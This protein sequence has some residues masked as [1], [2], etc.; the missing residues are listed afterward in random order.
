MGE[1]RR[2]ESW[3][4]IGAYLQKDLRTARRWE[5]EEGLPVHRQTHKR[6][7]SVYAYTSEIDVWRTSRKALPEPPP[8]WK[9]LLTGPRSLAFV[10]LLALFLIMVGNGVRPVVAQQA[11][12]VAKRLLCDGACADNE[13][14][15]STD[16][17]WMVKTDWDTGDLA[18]RDMSTGEMTALKVKTVTFKESSAYAQAPVFSP[19]MRQI[20]YHWQVE[21][22][23]RSQLR[24]MPNEVGGK[25][26]VLVDNPEY[27]YFEPAAWSPDGKSILV[28]V[29]KSS[30]KT[31]Q[32]AW[33][34]TAEG[35][36]RQIVSLGWR[37][38]GSRGR[39]TL[40]GDGRYIAYATLA[41]NPKSATAKPESTDVHIYVVSA[42]GSSGTE[43]VRGAGIN[44]SP[45]W[46]PDGRHLLFTSDRSGSLALWS[47]AMQNGR[48][49]G[50]NALVRA[51]TGDLHTMGVHANSYYYTTR[52]IAQS[53]A[54]TELKYDGKPTTARAE[55]YPGIRPAWSPDGKSIAYKKRDPRGPDG[56]NLVVQSLQTG[57][58]RTYTT[59]LGY[60]GGGNAV[61]MRDSNAMLEGIDADGKNSPYRVD[62]KSGEFTLLPS[63][64]LPSADGKTLYAIRRDP[65][66][67]DRIVAVEID[68][69]QER[70]VFTGAPGIMSI[71]LSPDGQ[72]FAMIRDDPQTKQKHIERVGVD[73]RGYRELCNLARELAGNNLTW[74][75]DSR[76]ILFDKQREDRLKTQIMWVSAEGGLPQFAGVEL[77]GRP[78]GMDVSPDGLLLAYGA[79]KLVQEMWALDNLLP[80]PK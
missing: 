49:V 44:N 38:P 14:N 1:E 37:N 23:G 64:G 31:W 69:G 13:A 43:V 28:L 3:K 73:G 36:L 59:K 33:V 63:A 46:S 54:V 55:S 41:L 61:W 57:E 74:S 30:D 25:A 18:I 20:V 9:T 17:R 45:T 32:L 22:D 19:D 29:E 53:I 10:A 68:S 24:V 76:R 52:Q 65:K 40:S 8:L 62:L 11:R 75:P 27:D 70:P 72:I 6:R 58:V 39:A 12:S 5:K 2:L 79:G 15:L 48:P 77:D 67:P 66:G 78:L 56:Y 7:A 51:D 34:S 26:R 60:T 42:D 35:A 50:S 16:G 71:A 47:M 4:D 80:A 21:K